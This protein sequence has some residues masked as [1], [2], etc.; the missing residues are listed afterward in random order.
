MGLMEANKKEINGKMR[1]GINEVGVVNYI[2]AGNDDFTVYTIETRFPNIY[3]DND[4]GVYDIDKIV[5][6]SQTDFLGITPEE[7]VGQDGGS[8][9]LVDSFL[10]WLSPYAGKKAADFYHTAPFILLE[11]YFY[12]DILRGLGV[13]KDP[14]RGLKDRALVDYRDGFS[15]LVAGYDRGGVIGG[16]ITTEAKV[17]LVRSNI[18]DCTSGNTKIGRAHV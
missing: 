10:T 5:E 1:P 18:Y 7:Y 3:K 2:C 17:E 8:G 15:H 14:Y 4:L 12:F 11:H 13:K 9:T 16:R 6:F